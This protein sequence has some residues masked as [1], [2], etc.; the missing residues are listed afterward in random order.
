MNGA[1]KCGINEDGTSRIFYGGSD[2]FMWALKGGDWFM[3]KLMKG[4]DDG[5]GEGR[6]TVSVQHF[7]LG[8]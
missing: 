7:N 1:D 3:I 2:I 8:E 4:D 6:D 5:K